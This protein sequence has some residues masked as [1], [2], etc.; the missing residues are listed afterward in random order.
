ML[1][2]AAMAMRLHQDRLR[3]ANPPPVWR[4]IFHIMAGS[5]VPVVGLFTPENYFILALA[6]LSAVSLGLDLTRFRLAWINQQFLRWLA[7]LL[8]GD[9]G[10]HIT[11]ATFMLIAG[12]VAFLIYD[13]HVAVAAMLFLALGDPAAALIGR[14]MPGPRLF[15]KSPGGT[16]AFVAVALAVVAVLAGA[17]AVQ[18]HWGLLVGAAVAGL[19]EL[20]SLPPDDNLTIPL[21]SGAAMHFLGA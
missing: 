18:Y 19:V 13:K 11:G 21:V 2:Y 12:L 3:V 7:P 8:K 5:S 17:G 1:R 9:E 20:A 15:R 16:A 4:R 10:Q 14:R 6:V